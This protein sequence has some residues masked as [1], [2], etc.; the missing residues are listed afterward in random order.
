MEQCMADDPDLRLRVLEA[1]TK[2]AKAS[3]AVREDFQHHESS[4]K[5]GMPVVE[6][7]K[8]GMPVAEPENAFGQLTFS[9]EL[10]ASV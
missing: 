9:E 3:T 5:L 6:S 10:K 1:D 4:D 2:R 8:L 7:E